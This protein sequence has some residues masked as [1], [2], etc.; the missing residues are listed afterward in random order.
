[1]NAPCVRPFATLLALALLAGCQGSVGSSYPSA[2]LP[3]LSPNPGQYAG[4]SALRQSRSVVADGKLQSD[5]AALEFP[6]VDG[7]GLRLVLRES[8]GTATGSGTPLPGASAR[9]SASPSAASGSRGL[10]ATPAAGPTA[11]ARPAPSSSP[12]PAS[13]ASAAPRPSATAISATAPAAAAAAASGSPSPAGT[14]T[15]APVKAEL[16]LTTYPENAPELP[17]T[18]GVAPRR[19]LVRGYLILQR[20]LSIS[21]PAAF[22]FI[23]PPSERTAERAF[24]IA[25]YESLKRG[26]L[27]LVA[28]D[29]SGTLA[30]E[31]VRGSAS[32]SE[33][34]L[35]LHRGR[36]YV[37][38]LYAADL[39]AAVPSPGGYAPV[40][41]A[42]G[43]A[44][45]P[46][47]SGYTPAPG[48]SGS[49]PPPWGPGVTPPP[50]AVPLGTRPPG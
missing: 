24:T 48:A 28:Q 33:A 46:G 43:Y 27:K 15:S 21:G 8:A 34:P 17:A 25:V 47:A 9:A 12:D 45:A 40:P 1:M 26:K 30:G 20:D 18:A 13:S 22:E 31:S 23:L 19:A 11:S 5:D 50:G 29:P 49:T 44:P 6:P 14:A 3:Q 39:P 36:G 10:G 41:G 32:G 37:A 4:G 38:L 7:F 35:L 2:S 42:S 16:K